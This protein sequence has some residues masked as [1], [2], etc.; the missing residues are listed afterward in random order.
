MNPPSRITFGSPLS[1]AARV[2]VAA[3]VLAPLLPSWLRPTE[4]VILVQAGRF[5]SDVCGDFSS[6]SL[7]VPVRRGT[8]AG[9]CPLVMFIDSESAMMFGRERY[10]EPKR[11]AT[12]M[13]DGR[14]GS[15]APVTISVRREDRVLFECRFEP[16]EVMMAAYTTTYAFN[17]KSLTSV[18]GTPLG[19][20]H[21]VAARVR[22]H[23]D[24]G[25][26][27]GATIASDCSGTVARALA[28][29]GRT[30]APA[31]CG[32]GSTEL[33][34]VVEERLTDPELQR[35]HNF[36]RQMVDS[37]TCPDLQHA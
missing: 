15:G 37:F 35:V 32:A 5:T 9:T 22:A 8:S 21:L 20:T 19:D 17:L 2:P 26:H 11:L 14:C 24:G 27:G 3:S 13:I 23:I 1:V 34:P 29:A 30:A 4:S 33:G 6:A 7:S 12:V 18:T 10:G 31:T 28:V 36:R 25:S 16:T